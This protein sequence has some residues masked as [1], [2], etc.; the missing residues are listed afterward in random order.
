MTASADA[1]GTTAARSRDKTAKRP[2]RFMR[3]L[4]AK[5]A[6]LPM[7][8]TA[9][10]IFVGC[11]LWTIYHSFTGSRLLPA[12]E[13]WVGLAQYERLW[14]TRRWLVSI[15]NL[16]I[17]GVCSLILSLVIGFTPHRL[18]HRHSAPSLAG[19][20]DRLPRA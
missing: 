3:N 4:T 19:C 5:V 20:A 14:D 11:T 17:Y 18:T 13:K 10:V 2:V 7:I 15:E 12:P 16:A 6:T 8:L 9:L 1:P